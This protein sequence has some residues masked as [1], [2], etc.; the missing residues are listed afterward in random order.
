MVTEQDMR[1][2]FR[3]LCATGAEWAE[4]SFP[5]PVPV[6]WVNVHDL[7]AGPY[8]EHSGYSSESDMD[9]FPVNPVKLVGKEDACVI[10]PRPG[11]LF[12]HPK[13]QSLSFIGGEFAPS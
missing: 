11:K 9:H 2:G 6:G 4:R 5:R 7:L 3:N 8:L 13:L 1:A 12:V 10:E